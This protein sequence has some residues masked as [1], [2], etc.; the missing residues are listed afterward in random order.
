MLD[1]G[2]AAS[3]ARTPTHREQVADETS[4]AP[5]P[6]AGRPPRGR[7]GSASEVYD[8]EIP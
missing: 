1:F 4:K 8:P 2:L 7:L 6:A 3:T 5:V